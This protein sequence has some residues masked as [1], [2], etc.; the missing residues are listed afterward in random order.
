M[1]VKYP[2]LQDQADQSRCAFVD[3]PCERPPELPPDILRKLY[4]LG[5]QPLLDHVVDG[6][7]KNVALPTPFSSSTTIR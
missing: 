7:S 4:Q 6:L 3:D 5:S 2:V 1:A